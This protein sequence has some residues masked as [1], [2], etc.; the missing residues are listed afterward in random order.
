MKS[1]RGLWS[2]YHNF[3]CLL[4]FVFSLS[5]QEKSNFINQ[6]L[7]MNIEKQKTKNQQI[8]ATINGFWN[9]EQGPLRGR[10]GERQ[11]WRWEHQ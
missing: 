2:S 4:I 5:P 3:Q 11:T 7:I 6:L 8:L 10:G 9:T 1:P